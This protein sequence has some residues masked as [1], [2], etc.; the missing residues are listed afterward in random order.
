V[1]RLLLAALL[2]LALPTVAEAKPFQVGV[3]E[4]PGIAIDDAGTVYVGWQVNPGSPGEQVQFCVVPPRAVACSGPPLALGFPGEGYAR[5]RVSVLLP[6]P[7]V[8]DVIV[9]RNTG[10]LRYGAFLTRSTDGGHTFA[11]PVRLSAQQYEE[12]APGPPGRVALI[13]GPGTLHV[14]SAPADGSGG[15]SDGATLGGLLDAQ[16]NDIAV[17]GGDVFAA[18]SSAQ[19]TQAFRL[20]AGADPGQAASWQQL[21]APLGRQPELAGG[22]AGLVA[23]LEGADQPPDTLFVQRFEGAAW[24]P[25]VSVFDVL[26]ND[27][28]LAQS[29]RGRL[30]AVKTDVVTGGPYFLEY[31]T[32]TDGGVLWSSRVQ[33]AVYGREYPSDLELASAS[34]G[35]GAAVISETLGGHAVRVTRFTPRSAPVARRRFRRVKARVQLRSACDGEKLSLVVEAA[36]GNRPIAPAKALRRARFGRARGARRGFRTRFRA[37]Y[38]LRRSRARI[39]V[40]VIPRR[41]K[42]RTL[43]LRVRRC[44]RT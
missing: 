22:P 11:P 21:P 10:P 14:D 18:S 39:P 26:N 4:N 30:T 25:P 32:S 1:R 31:A 6:A 23:M 17:Q 8:V 34:D 27:F 38:E 37:R 44:I 5:S 7:N 9:P 42:A 28:E 12:A 15:A 2:S 3:G 40:R 16:F 24:S 41:G 33:V 36:R 19:T 29:A 20:P 13:G 43:R 35:R